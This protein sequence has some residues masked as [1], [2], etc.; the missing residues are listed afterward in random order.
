VRQEFDRIFLGFG[1]V[2]NNPDFN[3]VE[4]DGFRKFAGLNSFT[5][6]PMQGLRRH[7]PLTSSDTGVGQECI[8]NTPVKCPVCQSDEGCFLSSEKSVHAHKKYGFE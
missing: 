3:P 6:T 4:F 1:S 7:Q 8:S 5:P 2:A